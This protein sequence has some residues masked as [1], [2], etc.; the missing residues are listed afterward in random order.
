[1]TYDQIIDRMLARDEDD[2]Y[3]TEKAANRFVAYGDPLTGAEPYTIGRGITGPQVVK[4]LVW[5]AD[6]EEFA[7]QLAKAG[8]WQGCADNL[9][10]WF[11]GLCLE[12]QAVL[13]AMA[14]Q[15]GIHRLLAFHDTLAAVRDQHFAH[16]AECMRQSAWDRQTPARAN[17]M[18]LQME[19][20]ALQ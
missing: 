7:Y 16:A 3:A 1:M 2:R 11:A 8:A 12:R 10:P 4:G 19:S 5:D 17:R 18:A 20:G 13:A 14:Y 9:A 6:Q 15:M